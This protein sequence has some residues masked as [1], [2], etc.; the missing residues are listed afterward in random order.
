MNVFNYNKST[1]NELRTNKQP[2]VSKKHKQQ[3][4]ISISALALFI[5]GSVSPDTHNTCLIN[6]AMVLQW[7]VNKQN[8]FYKS[9]IVIQCFESTHLIHSV[10]IPFT[11]AAISLFMFPHPTARCPHV[12][13][14]SHQESRV[15]AL[16]PHDPRSISIS[17][18]YSA[19]IT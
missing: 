8:I 6:V 7:S 19:L 14:T 11:L 17:H 10:R 4:H 12:L 2:H 3:T 9:S 1:N 5:N 16:T 13:P 18:K 15:T